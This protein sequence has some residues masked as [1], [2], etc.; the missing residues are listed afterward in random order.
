[1][2]YCPKTNT[3]LLGGKKTLPGWHKVV[4]VEHLDESLDFRPLGNLL[5]AHGCGH[6]AR[7]AINAR[8]Q[9]MAVW[10]VSCAI[11]NILLR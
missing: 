5:L 3:V 11:I 10:A 9:S 6:L 4:V 8:N 2:A 1:M 7:V